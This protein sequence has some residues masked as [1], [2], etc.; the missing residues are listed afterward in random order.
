MCTALKI[1]SEQFYTFFTKCVQD[2][3]FIWRHH[4]WFGQ[5]MRPW[6]LHI[7]TPIGR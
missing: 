5:Y 6:L 3:Q 1:H 4:R 7:H 2:R